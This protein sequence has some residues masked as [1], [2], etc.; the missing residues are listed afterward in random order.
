MPA[1]YTFRPQLRSRSGTPKSFDGHDDHSSVGSRSS[2]V[3][4]TA[5]FARLAYQEKINPVRQ[6]KLEKEMAHMMPFKPTIS[7]KSHELHSLRNNN[8]PIHQRLKEKGDKCAAELAAKRERL[9]KQRAEEDA[10]SM[11]NP[12]LSVRS[13]ELVAQYRRSHSASPS[14]QKRQSTVPRSPATN[15]GLQAVSRDEEDDA[16]ESVAPYEMEEDTTS[17]FSRL[18]EQHTSSSTR[19]RSLAVRENLLDRDDPQGCH[20]SIDDASDDA[21][22][23]INQRSVQ[24]DDH[25]HFVRASTMRTLSGRDLHHMVQRLAVPYPR[26]NRPAN[27]F[28]EP[29]NHRLSS[30]T[31][32]SIVLPN[33]VIDAAATRLNQKTTRAFRLATDETLRQE[34]QEKTISENIYAHYT[35]KKMSEP[36]RDSLFQRLATGERRTDVRDV[37]RTPSFAIKRNAPSPSPSNSRGR[38]SSANAHAT[39]KA[40]QSPSTPS[41]SRRS[42]SRSEEE[43]DDN[44]SDAGSVSTVGSVH[45]VK[46]N[47]SFRS[48]QSNSS[49]SKSKS[50]ASTSRTNTSTTGSKTAATTTQQQ[51][52]STASTSVPLS[53]SPSVRSGVKT[54]GKTPTIPLTSRSS[55]NSRSATPTQKRATTS[56]ASSGSNSR[57]STPQ[58]VRSSASHHSSNQSH[59]GSSGANNHKPV[60]SSTV[61]GFKSVALRGTGSGISIPKPTAGTMVAADT[62]PVAIEAANVATTTTNSLAIETVQARDTTVTFAESIIVQPESKSPTANAAPN[63]RKSPPSTSSQASM[64][65]ARK[66]SAERLLHMHAQSPALGRKPSNNR[67]PMLS[68]TPSPSQAYIQ[69]PTQPP[70]STPMPSQ[71]VQYEWAGSKQN[72]SKRP[73]D[74]FEAKLQASLAMLKPL[75]DLLASPIISHSSSSKRMAP[76][77]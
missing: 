58:P 8:T 76:E 23:H 77:K 74:D 57:S 46:S 63:V 22:Y 52:K 48:L 16:D 73:S 49:S 3:D 14:P 24:G 60:T 28:I 56:G 66:F 1:E 51:R 34:E 6:Q 18:S 50:T 11:R 42:K 5:L 19:R 21:N 47:A 7:E 15:T 65:L 31:V 61:N 33:S 26:E 20:L 43:K 30:Q 36:Q 29:E 13:L 45:S 32:P 72:T 44:C 67:I 38:S 70:T 62:A 68:P 53:A 69:S 75:D 2:T 55:S 71:R 39:P 64:L 9:A 35:P 10:R 40:A 27:S 17:V 59:G 4:S 12:Q 54:V 37:I 25:K 41:M